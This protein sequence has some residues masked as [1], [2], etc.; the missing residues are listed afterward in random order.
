MKIVRKVT[1]A[2]G[3]FL[4]AT[5]VASAACQPARLCTLAG[6]VDGELCCNSRGCTFVVK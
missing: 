2:L 5:G 3:L 6:C 1:F 4:V